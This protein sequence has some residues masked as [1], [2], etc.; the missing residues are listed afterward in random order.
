MNSHNKTD[1]TTLH[2]QIQQAVKL[3]FTNPKGAYQ[4]GLS[5][6]E[7][8]QN[9][10]P[11]I[12]H[13]LPDLYHLLADCCFQ[14]GDFDLSTEF[15]K[16]GIE[17]CNT[18]QNEPA[19]VKFFIQLGKVLTLQNQ[20]VE[21]VDYLTQALS[22]CHHI[23]QPAL[24]G[25][26]SLA[27]AF[28]YL[29]VQE[30]KQALSELNKAF[31][32]F[33]LEHDPQK[34]AINH[35]LFAWAFFLE[36]DFEYFEIHQNKCEQLEGKSIYM[37][38]R[39]LN[40]KAAVCLRNE[41]AHKAKQMLL[42]G[43][44]L[45]NQHGFQTVQIQNQL[46]LAKIFLSQNQPDQGL[47]LLDQASQ[48]TQRLNFDSGRCLGHQLYSIFFEQKEDFRQA[49]LH[50]K[51]YVDLKIKIDQQIN[52]LRIKN[53]KEIAQAKSIE[54]EARIINQKNTQLEQEIKERKWI[55][56]ALRESEERYRHLANL[57]PLTNLVNRRYFYELAMNEI[58][59]SRRYK[60]PLS[61]L[62]MDID[63]F[64]NINDTYGHISGDAVLVWIADKLHEKMR[65]VDLVARFG[66]EEF[67]LLLPE[68]EINQAV[69]VADRLRE[70]F[71][72]TP[73]QTK[74]HEITL[75]ISIG[76]SQ[77]EGE[78]SLDHFINKAD[79]ALYRAKNNGRNRTAT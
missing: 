9:Q 79:Q 49:F 39:N 27:K 69:F 71:A 11:M 63:Y 48:A 5:I 51:Q 14:F 44:D 2:Q 55:E 64:K 1:L 53:V 58:H 40:I 28:T 29:H 42:E 17:R 47:V 21:A 68:T 23:N 30:S 60:R 3:K 19:K 10:S 15:I 74:E 16:T 72:S 13:H 66:G 35:C 50:H 70:F 36:N 38:C 32:I 77:Y 78:E 52:Q 26:I 54:N 18:I 56:D 20:Y 46:D 25:E 8:L 12:S 73:I 41:E 7:M 59:R 67:I 31:Q 6:L 37:Y 24:F 43:L 33:Y 57:D 75:T 65:D 62:M 34:L 22:I 76:I 45:C 61:M 4:A